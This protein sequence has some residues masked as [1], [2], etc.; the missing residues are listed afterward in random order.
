MA[1]A[2]R[3]AHRRLPG[4]AAER[5]RSR[6]AAARPN[7]KALTIHGARQHNLQNIDRAHPAGA[8]GGGDRRLRLGQILADVRHPRPGRAPALLRRERDRPGAHDAIDGWEHL[9]KIITIDQEPI[10]RIPRSN[11]AT[12]SDAFTPI[13]E[14]FAA[15]PE[16]TQP[17]ADRRA[18]SRSTCRAGAASAAKAPAC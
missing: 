18:T 3:L 5:A 14:A 1:A 15:T 12:Y 11:A 2:A 9:D 6:S 10:G 17:R 13:R 8:A 16:A 7:G 4:R